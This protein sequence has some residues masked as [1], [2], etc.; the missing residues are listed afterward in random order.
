MAV[1]IDRSKDSHSCVVRLKGEIDLSVVPDVRDAVEKVVETGCIQ[2]VL[3]LEAVE[4][5]DSTALGLIVWL[6]HLLEPDEGR[7]I[8]AGANSDVARI[9][10]LSGLLGIAPAVSARDSVDEAVASIQPALESAERLWSETIYLPAQAEALTRVRNAVCDLLSKLDVSESSLFDIKVAVGEAL[11]N[12]VR[13]GSPGGESDQVRID[14]IAYQDRVVIEVQ[15]TGSGGELPPGES[16]DDM[17]ASGGR[18]LVFMK[19]LMDKV[20]FRCAEGMGGT[21]VSMEKRIPV[22]RGI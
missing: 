2:V 11:A 5:I 17:F 16:P 4:Y 3:D 9:L 8:L 21:C 10:E 6:N 14:V 12:A 19:A 22:R 20:E 7:L 1:R 13:H 18:G 15:D